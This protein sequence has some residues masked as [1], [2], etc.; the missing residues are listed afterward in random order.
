LASTP[1]GY[2]PPPRSRLL[3]SNPDGLIQESISTAPDHT[4]WRSDYA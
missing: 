2:L 4:F 1:I 3:A